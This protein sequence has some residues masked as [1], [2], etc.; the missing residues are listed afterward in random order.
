VAK[1]S[2]VISACGVGPSGI[3]QANGYDNNRP[4]PKALR[5]GAQ[6]LKSSQ[7]SKA[8]ARRMRKVEHIKVEAYPLRLLVCA[9]CREIAPGAAM[10]ASPASSARSSLRAGGVSPSWVA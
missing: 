6:L 8:I 7:F 9:L 10:A 2:G 4:S 3:E 5:R 1:T